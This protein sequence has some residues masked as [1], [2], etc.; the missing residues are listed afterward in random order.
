MRGLFNM[1]YSFLYTHRGERIVKAMRR[2]VLSYGSL[3][4]TWI[5]NPAGAVTAQKDLFSP[6][7]VKFMDENV[8][9][10]DPSASTATSAE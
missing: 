9:K 7:F 4:R 6:E 2:A 1:Q 8:F 10:D 3:R 5:G